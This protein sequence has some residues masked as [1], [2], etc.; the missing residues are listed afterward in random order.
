MDGMQLATGTELATVRRNEI[1]PLEFTPAQRQMIRDAYAK[2]ATDEEFAVLMEIARVR[3]LNPLLRQIHF[4]SRWDKGVGREVWTSQVAIDGL[5]AIAERT[6]LYAGQDEPEFI[7]NPDGTI[8]LCKVRVYRKDWPR[9]AV[10]IAYWSEYVQVARDRTTGKVAPTSFWQRM[11][12]TMLAK[13]AES[14]AL[15]KAFPEDMSGLYTTEEMA[16]ATVIDVDPEPPNDPKPRARTSKTIEPSASQPTREPVHHDVGGDNPTIA[17]H[18]EAI[19]RQRAEEA[20]A[21]PE[22][23]DTEEH[24]ADE[25]PSSRAMVAFDAGLAAAVSL[26]AICSLYG[27][28]QVALQEEGADVEY[29]TGGDRG[30]AAQS[31]VR[32]R[33]LG[34]RLNKS[35]SSQVLTSLPLAKLLDTQDQVTTLAEAVTWW[36]AYKDQIRELE[37]ALRETPWY[38]LARRYS[39]AETA[40]DVK[41]ATK[42]LTEALKPPPP[43]GSGGTSAGPGTGASVRGGGASAGASPASARMMLEQLAEHLASKPRRRDDLQKELAEVCGSYLK[44]RPV[45]EFAGIRR[46]ALDVA[47]AELRRRGCEEPDALLNGVSHKVYARAM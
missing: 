14:L 39:G 24:E 26:A 19:E 31:R 9:P 3:R 38:A 34:H 40:T 2:K 15:R 17:E 42:A 6:G 33:A 35:E 23:P 8:K 13:C 18:N 45:F 43:S 29:W 16:Q 11:G 22:E 32:M 27:A 12:H 5:R 28:L 37:H 25:G 46:E 30:A 4:V 1:S 41:A 47:R 20:S 36:K 21:R 44:R 10:G 7:E